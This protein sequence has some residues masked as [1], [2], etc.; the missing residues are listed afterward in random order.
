VTNVIFQFALSGKVRWRGWKEQRD[1]NL[2]GRMTA[3]GLL[4]GSKDEIKRGRHRMNEKELL[5]EIF[6]LTLQNDMNY[7]G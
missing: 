3:N 4:N 6:E 5:E 7:L 2:I 1:T